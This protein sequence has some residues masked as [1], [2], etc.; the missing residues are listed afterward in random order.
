M[1]VWVIGWKC[2]RMEAWLNGWVKGNNFFALQPKL[3][4]RRIPSC[5]KHGH[6]LNTSKLEAHNFATY[7][8]TAHKRNPFT[9]R[10]KF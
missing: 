4:T 2:D 8:Y 6:E 5:D 1:D 7:Q 9:V 10:P 3:K